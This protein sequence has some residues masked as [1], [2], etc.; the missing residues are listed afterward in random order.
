MPNLAE[1]ALRRNADALGWRFGGNQFGVFSFDL[2]QLAEEGIVLG[3]CGR[4]LVQDVVIVV[5]LFD[6]LAQSIDSALQRQC[7]AG[8]VGHWRWLLRKEQRR[9]S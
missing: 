6:R 1:P 7:V 8:N 5:E 3:V 2:A 4:G 9:R